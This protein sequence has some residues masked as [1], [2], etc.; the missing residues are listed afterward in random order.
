MIGGIG[1]D[2]ISIQ[3][4]AN[5]LSRHGDRLA[6]RILT[7][8]EMS[9]LQVQ[10]D[11]SRFLA[12]RWAAKESIAK[13]LGTGIR[14]GVTFHSM[15]IHN[16]AQGKPVVTLRGGAL[17]QLERLGAIQ[18]LLSLSDEA[19]YAVAFAVVA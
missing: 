17:A 3:R 14:G 10:S 8:N 5:A 19:D 2:I 6:A 11:V 18:C 1:T 9:Q 13:A 7:D 12:K 15:E 4:M 16:D